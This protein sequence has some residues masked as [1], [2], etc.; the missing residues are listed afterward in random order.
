MDLN[1]FF[2]FNY[3][4]HWL[5]ALDT[6]LFHFINGSLSNSLF[7]WLMPIL[8]GAGNV[9]H[10]F[11][12]A[13]ALAFVA[14]M[15]FGGAR[16]RLCAILIL[17]A[18]ALGN[19]LVVNT[20]KH[21]V[22]RPRPC[23]AL[24]DVVERLGCT[25]SGSMPSAHAANWFAATMIAFIFYRHKL[26]L[27][28]PVFLMAVAVSLSRVYCG[29]HYPG[30]VLAGAILG[31]GYAAS[32]AVAVQWAWQTLGRAWFPL[33]H[34]RMPSLL[35]PIAPNI[36]SSRREEALTLNP[37]APEQVAEDSETDPSH[38]LLLG[39][40][41][42]MASLIG[43]WIYVASGLVQLS[44]DEAYQWLWSKH[45]AWSYYS[46]PPGIAWIQ[47]AGTSL[48]GDSDFGVRFFSPLFAA[49]LSW[50]AFS[51]LVREI[52]GRVAF[53]LLVIVSVTP[54][55]AAGSV[56][57]TIDPPLVLCW[58]WALVAGW[59]AVQPEG[60]TRDWA[61]VGVAM[62]LAFLCKY[63]AFYQIIC[64][65]IFFVLWPPARAQ[66]RNSG[67]W[68]ALGIFLLCTLPVII[69]NAQ[70][71][72][73]TVHHVAGNAGLNAKWT[74]TFRYFGEF[75]GSEAALL[76]PIFFIGAIWAA[77]G[78]FFL[79][80]KSPLMLY[81]FCMSW[82]VLLGHALYSFRARILPNWVAPAVP[83]MFLLMAVYWNEWLRAGARFVKPFLAVGL[84]LGFLMVVPMHDSDVIGRIAGQNLPVD[85]LHRVRAWNL[86]AQLVEEE[87]EKLASKDQ[88]AFVIGGEY[89]IVGECTFYSPV[90]RKAVA[91]KMPLVY[92]K[93]SD[94]PE[95][96]FYFWP[97]YN[98]RAVRR[99]ENAIYVEDLGPG[100]LE[101]AWLGKWLRH[102]PVAIQPP[103]LHAPPAQIKGEFEKVTDLGVRNVQDRGRQFHQLHLWACYDLK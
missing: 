85:P 1:I 90:A 76:N 34:A 68:L 72:W 19:G 77:A 74:P 79:R 36:R 78:T 81:L 17:L 25:T 80:K 46:K 66:L 92:C 89:A 84:A 61:I 13:V 86:V 24:S 6:A 96:Q 83:A 35:N 41:L 57:M 52:G 49:V 97:E 23:M 87:R 44:G 4:M 28:V 50:M 100:K 22:H 102:E 103:K 38:W 15:I 11:V 99:G 43:R 33:W 26:W 9:M 40:L 64:F 55:L 7:D 71:A 29:V 16:A 2:L 53:W 98:Y 101:P 60:Q 82:P 3:P 31:A 42:V 14:A 91:L 18:G 58:T 94:T 39:F 32:V 51:F 8:S 75:L 67:P 5:E 12:L 65:G 45:L 88:P 47:F 69:W 56:L 54:L 21:A 30:D 93:D 70:H 37:N 20:I 62:G 10:W 48:F 59:R 73:I 63:S 95:N 27:I